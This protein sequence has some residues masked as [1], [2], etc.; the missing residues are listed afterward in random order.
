MPVNEPRPP[1]A[2]SVRI[3]ASRTPAAIEIA[4]ADDGP[5]IPADQRELALAR[6]ASLDTRAGGTGLGLAIVA[7]TA[8]AYGGALR[9][10]DAGP[11]LRAVVTI[12]RRDMR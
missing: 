10:E 9:L 7:D 5:G 4:V 3:A 1:R 12:P 8:E 11:G 2:N 6:G